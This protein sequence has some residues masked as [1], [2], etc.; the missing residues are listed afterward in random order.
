[1]LVEHGVQR[2]SSGRVECEEMVERSCRSQVVKEGER[3]R[4]D[5]DS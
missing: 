2:A 3:R 5:F 4:M 1:M